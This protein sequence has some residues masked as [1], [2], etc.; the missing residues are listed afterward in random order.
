MLM[1]AVWL[2]L[3][4]VLLAGCNFPAAPVIAPT[5]IPTAALPTTA[6]TRTATPVPPPTAAPPTAAPTSTP[7]STATS[8]PFDEPAGCWRPPDDYTRVSIDMGG[9]V[10]VLNARTLAMLRH[11]QTLYDGPV[12]F[13]GAITQGSYNDTVEASFGTHSGGGAVDISVLG[14]TGA[15][16]WYVHDTAPMIAALRTAGFAAWV[17]QPNDLYE[18]SPIHIHAVAVGDAELSEAAALQL[19]G[20]AGYFRGL[21]GLPYYDP[22]RPDAHGGPALCR[23][24][25]EMG[26]QDLR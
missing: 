22:P 10:A 23:W 24:M 18:G 3:L 19:T 15:G 26:Y 12:D 8:T 21:D 20:P 1:R 13:V 14:R 17:R 4:A 9:W 11:A 7:T 2:L 16:N 6:P 25:V 5:L